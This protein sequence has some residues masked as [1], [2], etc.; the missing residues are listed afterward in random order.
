VNYKLVKLSKLSGEKASI[1]TVY[2]NDE[3]QT[4]FERFLNNN[5]EYDEEL[6][7]IIARLNTISTKTGAR[8]QFFKLNEGKPGDLV[9]A[10]YDEPDKVLRLYCIRYGNSLLILGGGGFKNVRAWQDDTTLKKE[11][12]LVIAVSAGIYQRTLDGDIN[13]SEDGFE[14][15]GNLH[16]N[17][18]NED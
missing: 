5:K 10:L 3:Q 8:E 6:R 2:L 16:F 18:H 9:C 15:E 11:A 7:S 12:E 13:L 4:L 14:I 17:E 1:Y